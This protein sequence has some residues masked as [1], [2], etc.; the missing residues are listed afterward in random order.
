MFYAKMYEPFKQKTIKSVESI[1][2]AN[3]MGALS[4]DFL[5]GFSLAMRESRE[6][7]LSLEYN[8]KEATESIKEVEQDDEL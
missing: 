2:H 4:D 7:F 6:I 3:G 1:V 8:F 5:N